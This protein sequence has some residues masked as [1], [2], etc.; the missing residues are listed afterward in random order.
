[1]G[2]PKQSPPHSETRATP[3]RPTA[4]PAP[5]LPTRGG[6][7]CKGAHHTSPSVPPAYLLPAE[8]LECGVDTDYIYS[9][10]WE[11]QAELQQM[12]LPEVQAV[13]TSEFT[14]AEWL[15]PAIRTLIEVRPS[16][17]SP[18]SLPPPP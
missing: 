6:R 3:A 1:M 14:E 12:S 4:C 7:C 11:G 15:P 9:V 5:T 8:G 13:A 16:L 18:P 17:L 10:E 2:P